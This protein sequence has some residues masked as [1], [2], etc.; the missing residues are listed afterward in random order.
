MLDKRRDT[1]SGRRVIRTWS[2]ES[3]VRIPHPRR[4]HIR[5]YLVL[6]LRWRPAAACVSFAILRT[7]HSC[8]WGFDQRLAPGRTARSAASHL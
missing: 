1:K 7:V 2:F 3:R 5:L 6:A 8:C 4:T